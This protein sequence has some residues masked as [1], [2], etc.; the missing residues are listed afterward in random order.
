M[1]YIIG[2]LLLIV[3]VIFSFT[4][5]FRGHSAKPVIRPLNLL[6]YANTSTVVQF[7]EDGPINADTLHRAV[8][9]TIGRDGNM[10]SVIQGYQGTV[11]TNNT[12]PNN[13]PAYDAFLHALV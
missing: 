13:E 8:R 4:F 9:V 5:I 1:R 2:F 6:D 10:V 12:Y 7:T 11:I 3:L